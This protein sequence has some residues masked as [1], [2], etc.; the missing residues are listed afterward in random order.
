MKKQFLVLSVLLVSLTSFSNGISIGQNNDFLNE[1]Q[2]V[3]NT[4]DFL[5]ETGKGAVSSAVA[6]AVVGGAG[7]SVTLPIVGTVA[8]A[9]GGAIL[10]AVG[11]AISN[12]GEYIIDELAGKH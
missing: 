9:S 1:R 4:K 10:G 5:Y 6:C 12:A 11:G 7:G 8:G 3:W 2:E